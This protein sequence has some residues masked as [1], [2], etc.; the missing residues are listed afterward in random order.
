MKNLIEIEMAKQNLLLI[1]HNEFYPTTQSLT[2]GP[3]KMR[4]KQTNRNNEINNV[5]ID[6]YQNAQ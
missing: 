1:L 3:W 5:L 2:R 6:V 4:N